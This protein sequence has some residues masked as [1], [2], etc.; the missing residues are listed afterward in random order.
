MTTMEKQ[1]INLSDVT[2]PPL[3][4]NAEQMIREEVDQ[5]RDL[6]RQHRFGDVAERSHSGARR[7]ALR[8]DGPQCL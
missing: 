2:L 8:C 6:L 3:L 7:A 4:D 5:E 1:P